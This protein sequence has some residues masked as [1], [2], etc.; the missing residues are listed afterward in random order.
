M[1]PF[2]VLCQ[3]DD[4]PFPVQNLADGDFSGRVFAPKKLTTLTGRFQVIN[5]ERLAPLTLQSGGPQFM[6]AQDGMPV[7][8]MVFRP[9]DGCF[10]DRKP[11]YG[12][13][14]LGLPDQLGQRQPLSLRD[15]AG[16]KSFKLGQPDTG[17]FPAAF[18]LGDLGAQFLEVA[19]GQF[20][21][22]TQQF[23]NALVNFVVPFREPG[24]E[25]LVNSGDLKIPSWMVLN[26]ISEAAKVARQ[27]VIID[28]F[29]VLPRL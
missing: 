5:I 24:T 23:L 9:L 25:F 11:I 2:A 13:L 26:L 1:L 3:A 29:N 21:L 17:D 4:F 10:G 19:G 8:Q 12:R 20:G 6:F 7:E 27:F 22:L 16:P 28:V 18:S 14:W 15:L